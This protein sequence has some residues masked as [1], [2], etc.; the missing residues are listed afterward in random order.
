MLAQASDTALQ[1]QVEVDQAITPTSQESR[2]KLRYFLNGIGLGL[3][4]LCLLGAANAVLQASHNKS[5]AASQAGGPAFA[6]SMPILRNNGRSTSPRTGRSGGISMS[7]LTT[8]TT[9]IKDEPMLKK[10]LIEMGLQLKVAS[11]VPQNL[12]MQLVE[13][14]EFWNKEM[15]VISLDGEKVVADIIAKQESK[16][17]KPAQGIAF[18]KNSD[19][20]FQ[21]LTDTDG[22]KQTVPLEIWMDKLNQQYAINVVKDSASSVG[23]DVESTKVTDM[24][25]VELVME[26]YAVPS[27]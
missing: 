25:V 26:R 3:A 14:Q 6:P 4:C 13:D 19:G 9:E 27:R 18:R 11:E 23:F 10:T 5:N 22:W 24:G 1:L 2:N 21:L 16:L 20:K 17:G 8:V 7:H 12:N 15:T